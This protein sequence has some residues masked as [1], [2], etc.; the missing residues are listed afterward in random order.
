MT[1]TA[2]AE[3][4]INY[5]LIVVL[6]TVQ[7]ATVQCGAPADREDWE[8]PNEASTALILL[9]AIKGTLGTLRS[10]SSIL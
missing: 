6:C 2:S 4:S 7:C 1:I 3:W 9:G 10:K 5:L 8:L